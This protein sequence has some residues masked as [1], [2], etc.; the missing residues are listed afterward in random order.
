[1]KEGQSMVAP[2]T[3]AAGVKPLQSLRVLDLTVALAGPVSTLLLGGLGA[4]VIKIDAPGGSDIAR[5]N[6]PYI[7]RDGLNYGTQRAG[8]TSISVLDRHRNKKS[9][10][11]DLKSAEG[12]GLFADMARQADVIVENFS[13]GTA[14]RLGISYAEMAKV[15][16][17]LIYV[18][19]SAMGN[20][21]AYGEIKAM[22][23]IIQALSGVMEV[24]GFADGPPCRVGFPLAD[25][26]SSH[27][28][29]IGVLSALVHRNNGGGGQ[30]VKVAMLDSLA[31]ILAV[32]HFDLAGEGHVLRTGNHHERLAPF[33]V[34]ATRDGHM[35]IAAPADGWTRAL[36]EA[37][38]MPEMAADPRFAT[39]GARARNSPQLTAVIEGWSKGLDA[40]TAVRRLVEKGV[41][42]AMVRTPQQVFADPEIRGRGA[43]VR[44]DHPCIPDTVNTAAPGVPIRFSACAAQYDKPAPMLGE[45]N[46]AIY[47]GLLGLSAE[48]LADYRRRG[49]I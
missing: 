37:M 22:D 36:F 9:I 14:E 20:S 21:R 27:Y 35:A 25:L 17:D 23:I 6:P 4:E 12:R 3:S 29:V 31:S 26:L 33:G 10:T 16:P 43:V 45:D 39:R 47:R 44:L 28:A 24:N 49:V 15:N 8:E 34:F 32:E 7:G 19:I 42:A 40:Q 5:E 30:H 13:A 46:E 41:S 18:S 2:D 48:E 1:M 11:L 38:G